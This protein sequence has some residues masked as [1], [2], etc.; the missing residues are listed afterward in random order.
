LAAL[1]EMQRI[2]NESV[3][4]GT[5]GQVVKP[6]AEPVNAALASLVRLNR[7]PAAKTVLAWAARQG[8]EPDLTTY[9]TL[10]RPLIR[11]GLD[12]EVENIFKMMRQ[13][14]IQADAATFTIILDG[15]LSQRQQRPDQQVETVERILADMD[16]AGIEANLQTYA[17]MIYLLLQTEDAAEASVK[18]VLTHLWGKG[19]ELS[20]HI[21]TM[22]AQHYF[23]RG[24]LE[25]VKSL[26]E[27]Q[28][29]EDGKHTDRVFWERVVRGYAE[30]GDTAN[31]LKYFERIANSLSITTSS[32]E[33]LLQALVDDGKLDDAAKLVNRVR[34]LRERRLGESADDPHARYW[35]H[36]FWHLAARLGL[37]ERIP[38]EDTDP[39]AAR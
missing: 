18:A 10:L 28:H 1:D 14:G 23:S 34:T 6:S 16:D 29:L 21:Y 39:A 13:Q 3:Q 24:N 11:D 17:K 7:M 12:Q 27:D 5:S 25:A 4:R 35:R 8:I 33:D 19:L 38:E 32:L 26:I 22:L 36:R 20:P 31:A 2:W 30:V 37:L 9:N 15:A